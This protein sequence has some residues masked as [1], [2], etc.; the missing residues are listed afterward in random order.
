MSFTVFSYN[1]T[2]LRIQL[3]PT[4]G[5]TQPMSI[6]AARS[7]STWPYSTHL[8]L[9]VGHT[10]QLYKTTEPIELPLGQTQVGQRDLRLYRKTNFRLIVYEP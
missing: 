6:S 1:A 10:G 7:A 4:H 3:N 5:W 8:C 9:C 2:V